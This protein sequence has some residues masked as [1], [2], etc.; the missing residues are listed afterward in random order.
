VRIVCEELN[1]IESALDPCTC[2]HVSNKRIGKRN[3]KDQE[4]SLVV[5]GQDIV[6][7]IRRGQL[8]MKV[9]CEALRTQVPLTKTQEPL[10]KKRSLAPMAKSSR[11]ALKRLELRWLRTMALRALKG[12]RQ[13]EAQMMVCSSVVMVRKFTPSKELTTKIYSL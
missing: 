3:E 11:A 2:V 5:E 7:E 10:V 6:E 1:R 8:R 9:T 13:T 4:A 12:E